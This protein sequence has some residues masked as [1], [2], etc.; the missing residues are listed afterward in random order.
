MSRRRKAKKKGMHPLVAVGLLLGSA[1]FV[2]SSLFGL[3]EDS[4]AEL[5]SLIGIDSD[6][7]LD[8]DDEIQNVEIEWV[9]L[10]ARHGSWDGDQD[11]QMVF[12]AMS[13]SALV[14]A[15]PM[16]ET[17]NGSRRWIG[18]DP[19]ELRLGVV[20][21]SELS[22]RAVLGGTVVGVGDTVGGCE[23]TA[24]VP[25]AVR[26]RWRGRE[27]TY[28]LDGPVPIEFRAEQQLRQLEAER[29][30]DAGSASESSEQGSEEE[31]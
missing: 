18:D 9:D 20:M 22:R 3:G 31:K 19:P 24:I 25:G 5:A 8:L 4:T 28:D 11:V 2:A 10:L 23:V 17:V 15:A 14:A 12:A 26:V 27:L 21:V 13:D 29:D 30:G 7:D 16:G 1:A 6:E